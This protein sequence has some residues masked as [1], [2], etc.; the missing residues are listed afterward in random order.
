MRVAK[1]VS[2]PVTET[3]HV[4]P[5]S[6]SR[7]GDATF[8]VGRHGKLRADGSP[9]RSAAQRRVREAAGPTGLSPVRSS[10]VNSHRLLPA[11]AAS[12]V[13]VAGGQRSVQRSDGR[14]RHHQWAPARL[15]CRGAVH[16]FMRGLQGFWDAATSRPLSKRTTGSSR[17]GND[18]NGPGGA[19]LV[20]LPHLL[21][22]RAERQSTVRRP[23][24]TAGMARRRGRGRGSRS[25]RVRVRFISSCLSAP[26]TTRTRG[27]D[28]F[29]R[30]DR[31]SSPSI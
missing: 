28:H 15:P 9:P 18:N 7:V 14:F 1:R 20:L 11:S 3:S 13:R 22:Q 8:G 27:P 10:Q 21:V 23:G 30:G 4:D 2:I 29:T 12:N 19:R 24:E 16:R 31:R 25:T 6:G 26:R 5:A 17:N